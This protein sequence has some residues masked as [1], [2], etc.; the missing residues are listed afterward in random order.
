MSATLI[1]HIF[2]T[3]FLTGLI[4]VIQLI[5]YPAF[6]FVESSEFINFEKLHTHRISLVV[7]PLMFTELFSGIYLVFSKEAHLYLK[8]NF[9]L[10][11]LIWASTFFLSVPLH[12]KLSL[13]KNLDTINKLVTTN[14]PRTISWTLRSSIIIFLIYTGRI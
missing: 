12:T 1:L 11:L 13:G 4:W 9:A 14:W 8:Y 6:R 2:S 3:F 5:H 7:I 10:V